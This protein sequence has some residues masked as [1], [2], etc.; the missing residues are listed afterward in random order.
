MNGSQLGTEIK[1]A[2]EAIFGAP[3]DEEKLEEFCNALGTMIVSHIQTNAIL[4][5]GS[6]SNGGGPVG[7]TGTIT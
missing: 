2:I 6:F 1:G 4:E 5:P 3:A 7:G